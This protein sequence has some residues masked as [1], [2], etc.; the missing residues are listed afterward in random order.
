M[1]P[2]IKFCGLTRHA[3]AARAA[4]LGASYVGVILVGGPR[5][6]SPSVARDV[7][8]AAAGPR[9]VAVVSLGPAEAMAAQGREA[10]ADIL[11]LHADPSLDDVR[12]LRAVWSG[13]IWAVTRLAA[14]APR[15][16][17]P[18]LFS[19][20]DA[21]VVDTMVSGG[22]GGSGQRFDWN[23]HAH[24]IASARGKGRLVLA[25]GLTSSN[26]SEAV[27]ALAPDV[28]DVSSGVEDA[29]GV[30]SPDRMLA[31]AEAVASS[32]PSPRT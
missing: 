25:G 27:R 18:A 4:S 11:Q 31:F 19:L 12:A 8:G 13:G 28:V 1:R 26:I 17:L 7:F 14:E 22:L 2:E 30:K 23:R 3:D 20:T 10:T 5:L 9:R 21:V 24:A 32:S 16:D 15:A 29:P 6:V